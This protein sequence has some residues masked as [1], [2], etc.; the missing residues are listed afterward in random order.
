MYGR[1]AE[2]SLIS[3]R[4]AVLRGLLEHVQRLLGESEKALQACPE[5]SFL[6]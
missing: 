4:L 5:I 6:V 2:V 1:R 3:S